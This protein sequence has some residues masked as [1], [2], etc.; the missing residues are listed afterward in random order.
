MKK[1]YGFIGCLLFSV[2]AFG[3]TFNLFSPASG[4]LKG[5]PATYVTTSA[6]STDVKSLWS[7]TCDNTTYLRGDGSC[8][9]PPGTGGGTVNSV[10]LSAPSIFSVSGS[11]VTTTGT[12]GLTFAGGQTANQFLATPDGV[13][14]AVALRSMVAADVPS[15]DLVTKTTTTLT[16]L[17]KGTGSGAPS[18]YTGT[19]CTNQFPRSIN[20]SGA[21]TCASVDVALDITGIT[22]ATNGGTGSGFTAFSGPAASTKTFILPNASSTILTSNAAVTVAQG[23]TGVATLTGIAKGNGPSAFTTAVSGDVTTLWGGTCDGTTY[24][25]GDGSCQTP[26]TG[27]SGANPSAT[28]GLTAVNGAAITFMRSDGAPALSQS[29]TP[30][31]TGVHAWTRSTTGQ[32]LTGTN[33]NAAANTW[34]EWVSTNSSG[35]GLH[36]T[37]TSAASNASFIPGAPASEAGL[38]YTDAA[39]PM[40]LGTSNTSRVQIGAAGNVTINAPSSGVAL[41]IPSVGMTVNGATIA[42]ADGIAGRLLI[43][44]GTATNTALRINS[45]SA[46]V[47][48]IDAVLS[49]SSASEKILA[50]QDNGGATTFGGVITAK[51]INNAILMSGA[52]TNNQYLRSTTTGAD[53]IFGSDSSSGA[54]IFSGSPA[55]ATMLGTT[56][57]TSVVIGTNSAKRVEVTSGGAVTIAAASAAR[58]LQVSGAANQY[59]QSITASSTASQSFGLLIDAGTNASDVALNVRNQAAT[60]QNFTVTGVGAIAVNNGSYGTAGQVLTSGGSTAAATWTSPAATTIS[61]GSIASNGSGSCSLTTNATVGL[62]SCSVS[63][64]V[65]TVTFSNTA[66]H[67]W[68]CSASNESSSA[69]YIVNTGRVGTTTAT[70]RSWNLTS[71]GPITWS[72]VDPSTTA[73]TYQ[74][75]CQPV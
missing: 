57:A 63:S 73:I 17:L 29:I 67:F 19:S 35:H 22:P 21:A 62:A 68:V 59:T 1:F 4:V 40:V 70:I 38:I 56:G 6:T 26:P 8:Q 60:L 24:L 53:S 37:H 66:A 27:G 43:G 3:A 46:T 65:M 45:G 2:A 5:N 42:T 12:L 10:A 52:T 51:A 13:A 7:G 14:G 11:P 36:L 9:T 74:I 49:N 30:T 69:A 23:G 44:D 20:V 16:G 18:A 64:T 31:W 47:L 15:L 28:I 71:T 32:T 54:S 50:F 61:G 34:S 41:A 48:S 72:T 25:R 33:S 39:V 58:S 75:T 55:Y